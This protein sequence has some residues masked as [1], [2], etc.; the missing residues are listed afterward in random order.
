MSSYLIKF[1]YINKFFRL[2]GGYDEDD[3]C[4]CGGCCGCCGGSH[5][6]YS[7]RAVEKSIH[8][9]GGYD[10]GDCCCGGCCS[11]CGGSHDHYI[12]NGY[13]NSLVKKTKRADVPLA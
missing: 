6:H 2:F 10:Y 5:D 9:Y 4:C 7:S 8:L 1:K 3:G 12:S 11:C 13:I